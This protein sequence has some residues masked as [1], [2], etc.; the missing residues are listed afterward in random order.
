MRILLTGA[1]GYIGQRLLPLLVE[2][3]HHV[4]CSVRDAD[5][6]DYP[7]SVAKAVS[8]IEV[9]F[10]KKETL[11]NIPTDIDGAYYLIHS[12][13]ASQDFTDME[14]ES[15]EAFRRAMEK[16]NVQ[17]V[18]YLTGIVNQE[19]LSEH[20]ASRKAVETTLAESTAYAFTALRAGII[21][22]SG[23]ASFEIV[24]DLVEKL[25]VLITPK[26]VKTKC[27]PIGIRDVLSY[28][29]KA[30]GDQRLY[31]QSFDS[32]GPDIMTYREIMLG[33]AKVRGLRRYI[34]NVPVMTPRLS[35]YWLYFVTSTT[36][37]LAVSLVDSMKVEVVAK[38]N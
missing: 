1:N 31:D 23:S 10:L 21:I 35:S 5:R 8:V 15:A 28:L 9:D 38:S 3:G 29:S 27:Q 36:Y 16:T 37:N 26:W 24:R 25:P 18:I 4:I 34:I 22:G 30:M 2:N 14:Q 19:H 13:S 11:D 6:F 7:D 17:H 32:Y 20:L 12:M 33:Y